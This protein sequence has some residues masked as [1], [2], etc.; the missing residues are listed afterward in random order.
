MNSK[1][2][3][4]ANNEINFDEQIIKFT[5][6]NATKALISIY[7]EKEGQKI[8]SKDESQKNYY[9]I[10]AKD[11]G[12]KDSFED[13]E[14]TLV[15]DI[16]LKLGIKFKNK[17]STKGA[18][19]KDKLNMFSTK[20]NSVQIEQKA[21]LFKPGK[22]KIPGE[23]GARFSTVIPKDFLEKNL[24]LADNN[25]T[26]DNKSDD[27]DEK[28]KEKKEENKEEE[29]KKEINYEEK[30][31]TK[32]ETQNNENKE[33]KV[34]EE[35]PENEPEVKI[36]DNQ[37]IEE[38]QEKEIEEK[39]NEEK[40]KEEEK[41]PS[42]EKDKENREN[43]HQK[44]K[45]LEKE[46]VPEN[47]TSQEKEEK[48]KE[49]ENGPEKIEEK[50]EEKPKE[51][52]KETSQ[53]T[54]KE[55][56]K[57]VIQENKQD[58][59]KETQ[60]ENIQ[61]TT[62]EKNKNI[63]KD[64]SNETTPPISRD[65]R[66]SAYQKNKATKVDDDFVVV[67]KDDF[68]RNSLPNP[69][70]LKEA[71]LDSIDY[72][73]Y[74]ENLKKQ[75]KKHSERESFCEG[76]FIA[77][78]PY[79][80]GK[81]NENSKQPTCGHADCAHLP[82]MKP[83]I[84]FRYPLK[85]TKTLELNNLAATI[86]FPTGINVCYSEDGPKKIQDYITPITN[87]KGER[88]YMRTLH[89][90]RKM[91]C[92]E[93]IKK[94]EVHPLKYNLMKFADAYITL[95]EEELTPDKVANIQKN[96]E[97]CQELGFREYIYVPYCICLISKYPYGEMTN[98]LNCIY[99]MITE[100]TENNSFEV[101]DFIMYLIH[102]VPIPEG[103]TKIR[104]FIPYNN[105]PLEIAY[106]KIDDISVMNLNSARVLNCLSVDNIIT[107]FRLLLLEK[108]VLFIDNNYARLSNISDGF[109]S[110]L[111]PFQWIHTYIPIM[112]DQMLKYLETFLPFLNGINQS[113]MN[114]V[115][116]V[117]A[118]EENEETEEV[119]L[120]YINEDKIKLSSSLKGKNINVEKYI[121]N[122]IP[123]LPNIYEKDLKNKL[124]KL[125]NGLD[126]LN[127]N[128]SRDKHRTNKYLKEYRNLEFNIRDTFVDMF[129]DMFKGYANY[130]SFLDGQDTVFNKALF[131]EKVSN[132]DK[133]FYNEIIDTQLFQQFTQN[134]IN[135]DMD[136]FNKKVN[137][138][139]SGEKKKNQPRNSS[140]SEKIYCVRPD[141]L[142]LPTDCCRSEE[143]S[144]FII[145]NYPHKD[146][147]E[148]DKG[149]IC[150]I[151]NI[152]VDE[153]Y[154]NKNCRLYFTPE[155][156]EKKN[157]KEAIEQPKQEVNEKDKKKKKFT[158]SIGIL[159][160]IRKMNIKDGNTIENKK[161]SE[162][163]SEKDKDNIK[164][165]IRD[166]IIKI[167]KSDEL[168]LDSKT[169]V[170]LQNNINKPFGREFFI[171]LLT[172]NKN[173]KVYLQKESFN[174]LSMLIKESLIFCLKLDETDK[175]L[176]NI[177]LLIQSTNYFVYND[178]K[179]AAKSIFD[180]SISDIHGNP[181]ITQDN[182]WEKWYDIELKGKENP[183]DAA[184]QEIICKVCETLI[185]LLISK[186]IVKN[187]TNRLAEKVFGKDTP[188]HKETFKMFIE[189]IKFAR[190]TSEA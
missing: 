60:K 67:D 135:T 17:Y 45:E 186:T 13:L 25:K 81:V 55:N 165:M 73:T 127:K 53:E 103:N 119:F 111:Y 164:E 120:I 43:E 108:K 183:D 113:L 114:K 152:I 40:G 176:E 35:K 71:F 30:E 65:S 1:K 179:S 24:K 78:F 2:F 9:Q 98:C 112:S 86:C 110:L 49:P 148:D 145:K 106:P 94:F 32:E 20:R 170:E 16:K 132:H 89:L 88:Y 92:E 72:E 51:T 124:K 69:N 122:N 138:K 155:S 109:I 146:E 12:V 116:K 101:N 162:E 166:W 48:E 171:S 142:K 14:I 156:L 21:P 96:L 90:Y 181:K 62:N 150:E 27:L 125:R 137:E 169:K 47:E 58:I 66:G 168:N 154:V 182:F 105:S 50:E 190:Y 175:I 141:F 178:G 7:L 41:E 68:N 83:E 31:K 174:L 11:I 44:E 10:I 121:K 187:I 77:S 144:K 189:K 100:S 188:L 128:F 133:K 15:N 37:K 99:T 136:Y 173:S 139:E 29:G 63:I 64:I 143:I 39:N 59:Q 104:F 54:S 91:E 56:P 61:E 123:T 151:M 149:K 8:L 117:F 126:T 129:A 42:L 57:E 160:R 153:K 75:G 172:S 38:E 95:S 93:Y 147:K 26:C 22:L 33:K 80:D 46:D 23:L 19:F 102:S 177:V 6:I 74:L 85:D 4:I 159:E 70:L 84:I 76:F 5:S 82:S 134:V 3:K 107:I 87:Q 118:D 140:I 52:T 130:L 18:S 184:K 158:T 115:A 79:K 180:A 131:M 161:K 28:D 97:L 185:K 36:D 34:A 157:K 163:L 167:F